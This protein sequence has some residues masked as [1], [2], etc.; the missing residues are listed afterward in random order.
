MLHGLLDAFL[1]GVGALA[2]ALEAVL[3]GVVDLLANGAVRLRVLL[4]F[5]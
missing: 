1:S 4:E 2:G 5:A 3:A